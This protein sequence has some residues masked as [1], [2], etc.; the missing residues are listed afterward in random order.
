MANRNVDLIIRAKD[1]GSRALQ[2][3]QKALA[4]LS[5]TQDTVSAGAAKMD[6]AL[7]GTKGSA[8]AL[9]Q[10]FSKGFGKEIEKAGAAFQRVEQTVTAARSAF[11]Q[12]RATLEANKGAY[13]DLA[14][15]IEGAQ[16]AIVSAAIKLRESG[17]ALDAERLTA[18]QKA[19]AALQREASKMPALLAKQEQAVEASAADLAKLEQTALAAAVA[20][21]EIEKT[22]MR[23]AGIVANDPTRVANENA[24]RGIAELAAAEKRVETAIRARQ[25]ATAQAEESY[26]KANENARRGIAELARQEALVEARIRAR[27]N[28]EVNKQARTGFKTLGLQEAFAAEELERNTRAAQAQARAYSQLDAALRRMQEAGRP[29]AAQQNQISTSFRRGYIESEALRGSFTK[30]VRALFQIGAAS[31]TAARQF[32]NAA[33]QMTNM[34]RVFSAFY[35]DSRQALS[36]MQRLRGEVLSLT[37]SF[38]GFYGVFNTGRGFY[39]AFVTMEA[40]TNRVSAAFQQDAA[41][42][43]A[44]LERLS[45]EADRLGI[46]FN[47]LSTSYSKFLLSGQ[48]AGIE[49]SKLET[50]FRQVTE[51]GRVLKLSNEDIEGTLV[52][53]T[54]IAGK[55]TLQM[56]ELRQQLGDRLPGAVGL[57]AKSLGYATDELDQFYKDV[58]N[59]AISAEAGLVALGN[60]LEEA[61]GGQLAA[62]LDSVSAKAGRLENLFFKR[63]LSAAN[64]GFV[65]GIEAVIESL[66]AFLESEQGIRAFEG[67]GALMGRLLELIPVVVENF[68]LLVTALKAF[69]A[70]KVAQV[71]AGLLGGL[72][73]VGRASMATRQT[74]LALNATLFAF[75]P[76]A[77]QAM[78]STTRLGA[79]L[80]GLRS[81][82]ATVAV[83]FRSLFLSLGGP[84]G[85]AISALTF[86]SVDGLAATDEAAMQLNETL[87]AQQALVGRVKDAYLDAASGAGEW[88]DKLEEVTAIEVAAGVEKLKQQLRDYRADLKNTISGMSGF[89]PE[90]RAAMFA[91]AKNDSQRQ[92]VADIIKA[93]EAFNKAEI[94]ASDYLEVL[95]KVYEIAPDLF[96]PSVFETL[97]KIAQGGKDIEDGIA[98]GEA[99]L[100][101]LQGTATD[102][103]KVLLGLA[104][105]A[106]EAANQQADAGKKAEAF[107]AA[108]RELA[109]SVPELDAQLKRVEGAKQLAADYEKALAAARALPDA[110]M[111]IAAAQEALKTFNLGLDS[112]A[113]DGLPGDFGSASTGVEAAAAL[114]RQKEGFRATPYWDVN[115]YRVGYGSDTITL[116]D[117]TI[118]KVV[119]GMRVSVADANRDLIRRISTE[120]LP[121]ARNQVGA[122]RF[123]S[124]NPQ[125]QAALVSIAYNYGSLPDRIIEALRTGSNEQIAEAIRGLGGDNGG[126]N[127][128]RRNAEAAIFST[129]YGDAEAVERATEAEKEAAEAAKKKAEAQ[130]DYRKSRAEDLDNLR[131]ETEIEN[132]RL[133]DQEVAKALREAEIEAKKVGLELTAEER[134]EIEKTVRA[135]YA[136]A[137]A[138]ED[139]NK[140]LERGKALEEE[141]ARLQERKS[142]LTDQLE[143]QQA[144]GDIEAAASTQQEL[145]EI[146]VALEE[147]IQKA[148]AFWQ[149]MGGPEAEKAIIALQRAQLEVEKTGT[150]SVTTG[151]QINDMF[152]DA[153]TSAIDRFARRVA[154]GENAITAFKEEFLRMA[155][156][157]LIQ[158]AQM[159]IRQAI[160]NALSGGAAG[161]GVGGTVAGWIN[162][163]F[164]HSGGMAGTRQSGR[165]FDPAIFANA[166][167]YHNGGIAGLAPN[168]VPTILEKEEEVLTRSD[169]RHILNGGLMGGKSEPPIVNV[170]NAVDGTDAMDKALA[171]P[172]GQQIFLNFVRSNRDS[173]R[174]SLGV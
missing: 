169:P 139:K 121:K 42:T 34:R 43:A 26:R 11:D 7:A 129:G 94:S 153:A 47:T 45:E 172:A 125:Q 40:A 82:A 25:A 39:E 54:Q 163:M 150:K 159:I 126:V 75:S 80:R 149:A 38:V 49:N 155:G 16:R 48:Q 9:A 100:R 161:G 87:T 97:R 113:L 145:D 77:Y 23:A 151:Q 166:V 1:Q 63:Q 83:G 174:A 95:N 51:A 99:A 2:Q 85:I 93:D 157:I 19:Y 112:L 27:Q 28:S 152:A 22:K 64:A 76:A 136:A 115:A 110:I 67:L 59:G 171:T 160:F 124:F 66:N 98:E 12:Q 62:A 69:V 167:R 73:D 104:K 33:G 65:Q 92:L 123:D 81:I 52:A 5:T 114:L 21:R 154:D 118:Q 71:A 131:F 108:L 15:Q 24:R 106:E 170:V 128:S 138:E 117:G 57:V 173:V 50:I 164:N 158:I 130:E 120:F 84:I 29:T 35:G 103:D 168:E 96:P 56:E 18:A 46:S 78:A 89:N 127:R 107:E 70:I 10:Q 4:S 20:L 36:L 147:A 101:L 143:F 146:N 119:Q 165:R 6:A 111:R 141:V 31:D 137:Q 135:R 61:Y 14:V 116:S 44:E 109:K 13:K 3:I 105:S 32:G 132:Q 8:A 86:F 142:L 55:G 68:D 72:S 88:K 133:A 91:A 30:G 90:A 102:A 148:L 74:I 17:S 122:E 58:T 156:E 60:G 162:G 37:A 134:A 41:L 144:N 53:L 79:A 140:A